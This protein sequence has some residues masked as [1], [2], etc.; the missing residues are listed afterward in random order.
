VPP[1]RPGIA[2]AP[3]DAKSEKRLG[4]FVDDLDT[5]TNR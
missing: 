2:D 5:A 3:T 1:F 4:E